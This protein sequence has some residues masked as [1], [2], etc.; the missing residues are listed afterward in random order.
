MNVSHLGH[1]CGPGVGGIGGAI[2]ICDR[3]RNGLNIVAPSGRV[4]EWLKAPD[5]K[6]PVR[7]SLLWNDVN[8]SRD[9]PVFATP[10]FL[11]LARFGRDSFALSSAVL[12]FSAVIGILETL[13]SR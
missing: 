12:A 11:R 2:T 6:L 7:F 9:L 13:G 8:W 4:A 1:F 10:R 5:S 3:V